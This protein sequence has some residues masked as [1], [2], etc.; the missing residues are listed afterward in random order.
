MT[1]AKSERRKW[2]SLH[3]RALQTGITFEKGS[4]ML[5]TLIHSEKGGNLTR[6]G[7]IEMSR[8]DVGRGQMNCAE[9]VKSTWQ[10]T[11]KI[12]QW[13]EGTSCYP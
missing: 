3:V 1:D 9:G 5:L 8:T 10:P 7:A 4:R 6:V 2:W 12:S 13:W 11:I